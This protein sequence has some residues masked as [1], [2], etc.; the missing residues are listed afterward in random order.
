MLKIHY[1]SSL[2]NQIYFSMKKLILCFMALL[3]LQFA[4]FSAKKLVAFPGAEGFGKYAV[5]GRGG[6]VVAVTSLEDYK[7]TATPIVGTLRWAL[8]Q[9]ITT[10]TESNKGTPTTVTHYTPLTIVFKVSG[11]IWLKEDLK[12]SRD[13]L[14]IAGQTAPGDGICIAGHSVLWNGATGGQMFYFGPRRKDVIVR[15]IRFRTGYPKNDDGTPL[16]SSTVVTYGTDMENYEN[17]IFDHCSISW[18]N[19]EC[20]ATYDTKFVS[21]Q[22]CI[23]SE[24]LYCAYHKKG[25]RSYGGVWGGQ[26]A[27]YHHNLLEHLNARCTRFDGSRAHDTMAVIDYH[28]NVV[29][30][31]GLEGAYG[32]EVYDP[33]NTATYTDST[34][35]TNYYPTIYKTY[36]SSTGKSY[37]KA[38]GKSEINMVNN[39]YKPGPA[40]G[41]GV[42]QYRFIYQYDRYVAAFPKNEKGKIYATGNVMYGN[43]AVTANNWAGGIQLK[44]YPSS[45]LDSFKLSTPSSELPTMTINSA[46]EAFA[47]VLDSAGATLPFRDAHDKRLVLE[48][49][50]GTV[51]GYGSLQSYTNTSTY[52]NS[53]FYGKTLGIIDDPKVVGG[54]PVFTTGN[55]PTDTDG[56]GMPDAWETANGLNPADSTDGNKTDSFG[57]TYL[58]NYLNSITTFQNFVQA[59]FFLKGSL[60]ATSNPSLKWQDVSDNEENYVIE[61]SL[62]DTTHFAAID[63]I[64][65]NSTSYTDTTAGNGNTY[66]YR[67][68]AI[69]NSLKSAYTDTVK[70]VMPVSGIQLNKVSGLKVYPSPV[71]NKLNV[72]ANQL[73]STVEIYDV[74]GKLITQAYVNTSQATIDTKNY[75]SGIYTVVVKTS[76]GSKSSVKILKE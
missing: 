24:G 25:L 11:T 56:D 20:F 76:D 32:G 44:Y 66:I 19:E 68:R 18:A 50:N 75:L 45:M 60:N 48:A 12:V 53:A 52:T 63:T 57:Y 43:S 33:S 72:E 22:W 3:C 5:G 21:V 42:L 26:Y 6:K 1:F 34:G 23:I 7:S 35:A 59:P 51:S 41:A 61:R 37:Y 38:A 69:T 62:N 54:W 8:S 29:Y 9:Y 70:I 71:T 40:T 46:S 30:N 64:A 73:I 2:K 16:I 67:V 4:A 39:Y 10:S 47:S 28:N 14:T 74:S 27:S 49:K 31:W 17:V 13:S 15:Y 58:E 55:I 65:A 36:T